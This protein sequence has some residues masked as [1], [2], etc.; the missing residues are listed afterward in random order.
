MNKNKRKSANLKNVGLSILAEVYA[1]PINEYICIPE[2]QVGDRKVDYII[3]TGRSRM[4]VR[5]IEIKG[6]D[7]DFYDKNNKTYNVKVENDDRQVNDEL[8]YFSKNY[9]EFRVRAH[10]YREEAENGILKGIK[11]ESWDSFIHQLTR[12]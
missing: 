12:E 4:K 6:A 10:K 8:A 9:Y 3:F 1:Y 5:F 2:Y 11:I 7:F